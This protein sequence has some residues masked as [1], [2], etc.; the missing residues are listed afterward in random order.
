MI[1]KINDIHTF[2]LYRYSINLYNIKINVKLSLCH[3]FLFLSRIM[4]LWT[5]EDVEKKFQ[6][7]E[8]NCNYCCRPSFGKFLK[9]YR[10][11]RKS[12]YRLKV[13]FKIYDA[14]K[15]FKEYFKKNKVFFLVVDKKLKYDFK[16]TFIS[17]NEIKE[18]RN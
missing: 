14:F 18:K 9:K 6:S 16:N 12:F 1:R 11:Y 7:Y 15:E 4:L 13:K 10:I 3:K 17:I 5:Q 2:F 8:T